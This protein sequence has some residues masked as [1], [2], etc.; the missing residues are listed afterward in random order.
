MSRL[1]ME[2]PETGEAPTIRLGRRADGS[3]CNAFYNLHYARTRSLQQSEWEFCRRAYADGTIPFSVAEFAGEVVGTQA[4]IPIELI[5]AAGTY[6]SAK[7]EETLVAA[8]MRG[9]GL[10]HQLYEPLLTFAQSHGLESIWGFTPARS[11]FEREGFDIPVRTSQLL[12]PFSS[13][14][15]E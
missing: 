12:R 4:L 6:W 7:S 1:P 14:A 11:A 3:R 15:A 8:S 5:D 9:R 10:F 2:T 13:D